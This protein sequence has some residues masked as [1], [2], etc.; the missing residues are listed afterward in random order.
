MNKKD[1]IKEYYIKKHIEKRKLE[2]KLNAKKIR[3][4]KEDTLENKLWEN[5]ISR[6]N[7]VYKN[8]KNY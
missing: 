2:A 4:E 1:Y 3:L 6:I 8:K 7:K 5:L